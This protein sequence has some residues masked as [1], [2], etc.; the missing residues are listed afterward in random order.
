MRWGRECER[1]RGERECVCKRDIHVE[2]D[3]Q[4]AS[5]PEID[6]DKQMD[7]AQNELI[8]CTDG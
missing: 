2:R 3:S 4:S 5:Q 7:R 6:R 1:K 8:H